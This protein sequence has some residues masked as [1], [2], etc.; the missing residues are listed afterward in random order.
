MHAAY[1]ECDLRFD[2][3]Q[4]RPRQATEIHSFGQA[5]TLTLQPLLFWKTSKGTPDKNKGFSLRGPLKSLEKEGNAQKKQGKSGNNKENKE[6]KK[7]RIGGSGTFEHDGRQK[8]AV[9]A[10]LLSQGEKPPKIRKKSSQEQSSWE[11]LAL[12]PLKRQRK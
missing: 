7:A 2:S 10:R 11:L 6:S 4:V 5:L 3:G 9:L 12:L 1:P 8:S